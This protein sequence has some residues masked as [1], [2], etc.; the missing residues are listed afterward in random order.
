MK[1]KR[2][3]SRKPYKRTKVLKKRKKTKRKMT[4]A[5]S[6]SIKNIVR[7]QLE[8]DFNKS[9]FER[10]YHFMAVPL[11][12]P[13][14]QFQFSAGIAN[15]GGP[16]FGTTTQNFNFRVLSPEKLLDAASVLYN[17]KDS[18][19]GS[20]TTTG[21][22]RTEKTSANFH[23]ASAT[24]T[25]TNMTDA[26]FVFEMMECENRLTSNN[27]VITIFNEAIGRTEWKGT[28]PVRTDFG[29]SPTQFAWF[30]EKYKVD[31]QMKFVLKPGQ[32]KK[33]YYRFAGCI[34]FNKYSNGVDSVFGSCKGFK[35]LYFNCYPTE[36]INYNIDG[37]TPANS[38]GY[39]N[40]TVVNSNTNRGLI[41]EVNEVYKV[42]QPDETA[43]ANEG[44]FRCLHNYVMPKQE[45]PNSGVAQIF[46]SMPNINTILNP[47]V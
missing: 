22:F 36:T 13:G 41:V 25:L 14:K 16:T 12:D 8:C 5:A 47:V 27:T 19:A 3:V 6:K 24:Y 11:V 2:S 30:K 42:Q 7:R 32:S 28:E 4:R 31:K 17:A 29:V 40:R 1:R 10:N 9:V 26:E 35:E 21:N 23:Y 46:T 34:D 18:T 37:T 44:N 20:F 45:G 38:V 15:A 33:F 43:D 39:P